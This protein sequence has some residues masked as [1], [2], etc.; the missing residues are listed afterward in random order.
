MGL[1]VVHDL[2]LG[3]H[4]KILRVMFLASATLLR[5]LHEHFTRLS[6]HPIL[7]LIPL[8]ESL[9]YRG[10]SYLHHQELPNLLSPS[11]RGSLPSALQDLRCDRPRH[12]LQRFLSLMLVLCN[13]V[14]WH[15]SLL[16]SISVRL[17]LPVRQLVDAPPLRNTLHP[18]CAYRQVPMGTRI[19]HLPRRV[20]ADPGRLVV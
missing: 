2:L 9:S 6:C 10:V 11:I 16:H 20:C 14:A 5:V 7:D 18:P 19:P 1:L 12:L 15:Q 3:L 13:I 8:L 4:L 17:L